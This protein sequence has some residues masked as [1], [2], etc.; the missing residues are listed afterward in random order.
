MREKEAQRRRERGDRERV[1][2][3]EAQRRREEGTGEWGMGAQNQRE[4]EGIGVEGGGVHRD[5]GGGSAQSSVCVWR[6][7]W[8]R[9]V[10]REA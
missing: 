3:K 9:G 6:V 1:R 8:G 4:W 2:E 10:G 5:G 7:W